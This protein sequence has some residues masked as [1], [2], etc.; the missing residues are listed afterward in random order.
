[1]RELAHTCDRL[2]ALYPGADLDTLPETLGGRN[3][4]AQRGLIIDANWTLEEVET[5]V[6]AWTL[7]RFDGNRQAT[8]EHL[9]IGVRTLYR[10]LKD[11]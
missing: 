4:P 10:R 1:V 6:L 9:G 11:D 3:Q 2:T 8:A 7:Q 5:K